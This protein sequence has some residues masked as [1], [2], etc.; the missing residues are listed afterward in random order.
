MGERIR[1]R[2]PLKQNLHE[3]LFE[4]SDSEIL[5]ARFANFSGPV[6]VA[7]ADDILGMKSSTPELMPIR[8]CQGAKPSKQ[9]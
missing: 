1:L 4:S 8:G 7:I 2:G 3:K 9:R 5:D 6:P